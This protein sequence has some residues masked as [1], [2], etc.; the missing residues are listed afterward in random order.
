MYATHWPGVLAPLAIGL[1]PKNLHAMQNNCHLSKLIL[2]QAKKYGDRAALSY[3]DY[4]LNKWVP[5]SN[6]VFIR[7][8]WNFN[9]FKWNYYR[10]RREFNISMDT[11]TFIWICDRKRSCFLYGT[12]F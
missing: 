2:E 10:R 11:K 7:F 12:C 4:D 6:V 9:E 5:V 3:R 8:R 1:A